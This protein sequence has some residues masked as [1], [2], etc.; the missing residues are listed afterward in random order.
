MQLH[1]LTYFKIRIIGLDSGQCLDKPLSMIQ[2][3]ICE[4]YLCYK[5]ANNFTHS[6]FKFVLILRLDYVIYFQNAQTTRAVK[7]VLPSL[8]DYYSLGLRA[9]N[10]VA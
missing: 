6:V 8:P 1:V 2:E 5:S 7:S 4:L 10:A 3:F 9:M